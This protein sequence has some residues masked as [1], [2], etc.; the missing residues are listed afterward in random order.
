[1]KDGVYI[2]I[3]TSGGLI[4]LNTINQE[5]MLYNKTIAGFPGNYITSIKKIDGDIWVGTKNGGLGKF[6]NQIW[7]SSNVVN[8]T[9]PIDYITS[10]APGNNQ[11]LWAATWGGGLIKKNN[12]NLTVY[13]N[14]NSVI[15][16][17]FITFI[18]FYSPGPAINLA[19]PY[20]DW[21]DFNGTEGSFFHN[22]NY[23]FNVSAIINDKQ[24]YFWITNKDYLSGYFIPNMNVQYHFTFPDFNVYIN[25]LSEDS[26]YN[27]WLG[28]GG[29]G[30]FLWKEST[31]TIFNTDNSGLPGNDVRAILCDGQTEWI[32]TFD[33][34]LVKF[35]GE[36]WQP[37]NT[38][39]SAPF[40]SSVNSIFF[41]HNNKV[42]IGFKED[43][44]WNF[45]N[46]EW[47]NLN[48]KNSGLNN[49][50]VMSIA[51]D[52]IGNYWIGT[53]YGGLNKF[54]GTNWT[55]YNP[56][57]SGLS[58]SNIVSV[59]IDLEDNIWIATWGGGLCRYD[60]VNWSVYN[61]S[62]SGLTDDYIF[63]M[64]VDQN[65]NIWLGTFG[66]GLF[67]FNGTIWQV[68]NT[69][70]SNIPGNYISDIKSDNYYNI[71]IA[72]WSDGIAKFNN[73]SFS[74]FNSNNTPFP[75]NYVNCLTVGDSNDIF[76]GTQNSGLVK[77]KVDNSVFESGEIFNK[78]N[79][80]MIDNNVKALGKDNESN[81]W[82][83]F[84]EGIAVLYP[85]SVLS[86][87][88]RNTSEI[89]PDFTLSQNY[90]NPFNPITTIE[91]NLPYNG[92]V[93]LK[94]Y[95]LLGEEVTSVVNEEQIAGKHSVKF[96]GSSLPS[97]IYIYK[98]TAGNYSDAKKLVLLK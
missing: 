19:L 92:K 18:N 59:Q 55:N 24:N 33:G 81:I 5:K 49:N 6:T 89:L 58:D 10:L 43:G 70:N 20:L 88:Y 91:Y 74:T 72:T 77:L 68:F 26:L 23:N 63:S 66:S 34:G 48:S 96:D 17:N 85:D 94:V 60:G 47:T 41:D 62:N 69:D 75:I 98:L 65:D 11:D 16:S 37:V 57:N 50:Y 35:N 36:D 22:E 29:N 38:N 45:Q 31:W 13:N 52:N 1:M 79:S 93:T 84:D 9:L 46:D 25:I 42:W 80:G 64:Y 32:G 61:S 14:I 21:F 78:Y 95:N 8:S 4:K 53:Y 39:T 76:I 30:I 86:V 3:G 44:I 56:F 67:R 7:T 83:G 12:N 87:E 97:G 54:D 90:P 28:T 82:I 73:N 71:W 27:K 2:W 15:P 40:L 51:K